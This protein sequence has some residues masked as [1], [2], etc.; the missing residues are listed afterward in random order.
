MKKLCFTNDGYVLIICSQDQFSRQIFW[1]SFSDDCDG[2]DAGEA[3]GVEGD[4]V[5]GPE[6]GKVDDNVNVRVFGDSFF[7][8][9]VNQNKR[10]FQ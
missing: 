7:N 9:R 8:R 6:R 5:G 1:D 10:Y 3:H 4:V 2:L